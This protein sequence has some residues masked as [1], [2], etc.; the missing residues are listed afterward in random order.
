MVITPDGKVGPCQ[1]FA[2]TKKYF[3]GDVNGPE[4]NPHKDETFYEWYSRTPF[5]M[6]KCQTCAFLG[7]CGGGCAYS[8]S[9]KHGNIWQQ[10]ELFCRFVKIITEWLIWDLY[11]SMAST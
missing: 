5:N 7:N 4:Y 2:A 11:E 3:T 10:D 6:E 1:A 8:A 9:V